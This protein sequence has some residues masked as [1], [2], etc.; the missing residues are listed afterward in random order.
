MSDIRTEVARQLTPLDVAI[1]HV[2]IVRRKGDEYTAEERDN[3]LSV[4]ESHAKEARAALFSALGDTKESDDL[5]H[6]T[7]RMLQALDGYW[8]HYDGWN[9]DPK[10]YPRS[11]S[12]QEDWWNR[13][14]KYRARVQALLAPRS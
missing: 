11:R 12:D 3:V 13:F 14:E 1:T 4:V 9:G 2:D 6:W 5:R 7:R 10:R 8:L